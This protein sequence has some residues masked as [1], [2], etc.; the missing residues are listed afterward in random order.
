[1]GWLFGKKKKVPRVPFPE[2]QKIDKNALQFSSPSSKERIIEPDQIKEAV[3]IE[4]PLAFPPPEDEQEVQQPEIPSLPNVSPP[5]FGNSL[6]RGGL[7][8]NIQGMATP[9]IND[10]PLFVKVDVYQEILSKMD[11]LKSDFS[12]LRHTNNQLQQSEFNEVNSFEKLRKSIK[13]IHDKL[14]QVD[15]TLFK[16]E[17]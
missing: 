7:E 13:N 1:M 16:I 8:P 17:R 5:D 3:G 2:G 11:E 10:E 4:K 14:L 6:P 9:T 12:H 15:K